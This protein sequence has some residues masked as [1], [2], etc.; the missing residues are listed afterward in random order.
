MV[1][2]LSFPM[3]SFCFYPSVSGQRGFVLG[4][5]CAALVCGA[6]F[7]VSGAPFLVREAPSLARGRHS[8][9]GA[10]FLGREGRRF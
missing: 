3:L 9:I 10:P 8:W 4:Q 5:R 1:G 7:L 2:M 6:P